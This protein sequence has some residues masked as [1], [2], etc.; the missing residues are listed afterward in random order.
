M[1]VTEDRINLWA[2][3][4]SETEEE[5]CQNAI[6]AV[7]EAMRD[8]YGNAVTIIHQGS[9]KNRTNIRADS[10]VDI[11]VVYDN[12][13]FSDVSSLPLID[14]KAH[15]TT[16]TPAIYRFEQFKRDVHKVLQDKFNFGSVTRKNKCIKLVGNTYRVS[17]DIVPAFT[18]KRFRS[19]GD[20]SY[21]GIG[22]LTDEGTLVHS[23]PEHH[24]ENGVQKN[25]E[26]SLA[27]KAAVRVLKNTRNEMEEKRI[28]PNDSMPSFF[29]ESLVWNVPNTYFIKTTYRE[30]ARAVAGK[31]WADMRNFE[32]ANAY[33]EVSGLRWLLREAHHTPVQA[34]K[35]MLAAWGYLE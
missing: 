15:W 25:D 7:T 11:A 10:D 9:H 27:Y 3:A 31:V 30:D 18:S 33:T 34:E 29:L 26:T 6:R 12:S 8:R 28:I 13:Y 17:A 5:K 22:F 2:K 4:I 20:V 19:L 35:F 16:L 1:N 24:Y 14:Q 21:E 23:F 32:I